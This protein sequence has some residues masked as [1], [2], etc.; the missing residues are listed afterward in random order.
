MTR[1][2]RTTQLVRRF[3]VRDQSGATHTVEEWGDFMRFWLLE[4]R[5]TEWSRSGGRLRLGSRHVNP[6]DDP[7]VFEL[8][9]T[10]ERLTA[11]D[12]QT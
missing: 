7:N 8:P 10:G 9:D 11:V 3:N 4:G 1:Q 2:E 5:W 12:P 6:T